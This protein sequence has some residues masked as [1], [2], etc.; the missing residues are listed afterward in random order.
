MAEVA[1]EIGLDDIGDGR[2]LA[3]ADYDNDGD[4]DVYISNQG[5]DSVFYRPCGDAAGEARLAG[6][7]TGEPVCQ[8]FVLM[9]VAEAD[10]DGGLGEILAVEKRRRKEEGEANLAEFCEWISR[11]VLEEQPTEERGHWR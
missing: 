8:I 3:I 5:Q 6:G 1:G 11:Q 9:S 7:G 2:G 10:W 4:L